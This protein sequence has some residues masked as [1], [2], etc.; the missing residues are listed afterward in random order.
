MIT[1]VTGSQGKKAE[2]KEE[3]VAMVT[4]VTGSQGKKAEA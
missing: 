3:E 1:I 4:I 2:A